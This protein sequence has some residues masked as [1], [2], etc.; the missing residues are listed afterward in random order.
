[1]CRRTATAC[2][3]QTRLNRRRNR[4]Q[5]RHRAVPTGSRVSQLHREL[6]ERGFRGSYS[7]VR[8]YVRPRRP[9]GRT[10]RGPAPGVRKV[11]G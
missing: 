11:T 6:A 7:A 2:A 1:M 9:A 4:F 3:T 8:D 5:I 10:T